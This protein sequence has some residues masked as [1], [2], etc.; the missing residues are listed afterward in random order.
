MGAAYDTLRTR[1]QAIGQLGRLASILGWDQEVLM[2]PK[3]LASRAESR[4]FV[5][6]E[7]RTRWSSDELGDLLDAAEA[8]DDLDELDRANLRQARRARHE[9]TAVPPELA[10]EL[11]RHASHAL[12]AWKTARANDDFAA[13]APSLERTIDL[14]RQKAAHLD[15]EGDPYEVLMDEYEQGLTRAHLDA[16]F[17][18]LQ[19]I[20]QRI[21]A[22]RAGDT[23]AFDP[24][25]L[26]P[27]NADAQLAL[28]KAAISWIGFDLEAGRL[29]LSA[30][31]FSTSF[32]TTDVRLTTR[33]D[34]SDPFSNLLACMHEAGHGLYEAG[35]PEPWSLEP[36]GQ[37]ISLGVHESQSRLWEN[38]V[39]RSAAFWSYA[40]PTL[41]EH[42]P[43]ASEVSPE[44]LAAHVRRVRPGLIRVEADEVCY[45][46]HVQLRYE[47]EQALVDG[48]LA[49]ADLP[50]AWDA[51]M[52]RLLGVTVP[53][54]ADGCLQDIHWA[55]GA[56]G[57]FPTYTLGNVY[58]AQLWAAAKRDLPSVEDDIGRG[59]NG[60]LLAWLRE[61]VHQHGSR[62]LPTELVEQAT[63]EAPSARHL[64]AWLE[65]C[66][67]S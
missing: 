32:A 10:A 41:R 17:A 19:P 13:F 67:L 4:V 33:T 49:V 54:A 66:Y 14:L 48:D 9:A 20:A 11:T 34:E 43:Q 59:E 15:P 46:L 26:A 6:Q 7:A 22:A 37:A 39:G 16:L 51:G 8:E 12:E 36:V 40:L 62:W 52:E 61:R 56:I 31:P 38:M 27:W 57:Y 28:G 18:E 42:F 47:L 44:V 25:T 24:A 29:D 1:L 63:G 55:M 65:S 23:P 30:H 50:A 21:I 5:Q 45:N 3:A 58:A 35:L 2:P 60:A 53:N 64:V